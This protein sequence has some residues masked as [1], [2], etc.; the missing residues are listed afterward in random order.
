VM[1]KALLVISLH[2]FTFTELLH[3]QGF[4]CKSLRG[5]M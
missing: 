3:L 4:V 5:D 1:Q 2:L